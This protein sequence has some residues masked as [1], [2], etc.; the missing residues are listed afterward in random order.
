M[1]STS[2]SRTNNMALL[3]CQLD[4]RV[5]EEASF[6]SQ[7]IPVE[8]FLMKD[9]ELQH[10]SNISLQVWLEEEFQSPVKAESSSG[11]TIQCVSSAGENGVGGGSR[12]G[13][14]NKGDTTPVIMNGV[15]KF[16]IIAEESA[17]HGHKVRVRVTSEQ[18]QGLGNG[19][20]L[21]GSSPEFTL[22]KYMLTL[23]PQVDE[24]FYKDEGGK[25]KVKLLFAVI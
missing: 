12:G 18:D 23:G 8:V 10:A 15:V 1:R 21:S 14:G 16:N 6:L 25:S 9:N 24:P 17:I 2:R 7:P 22:H 13:S 5:P 19:L 3:G 20:Q 11:V 4:V